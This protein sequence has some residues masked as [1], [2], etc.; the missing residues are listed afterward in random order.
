LAVRCEGEQEEKDGRILDYHRGQ[1]RLRKQHTVLYIYLYLSWL[2][3]RR[4]GGL[5]AGVQ[6]SDGNVL[7]FKNEYS[8]AFD[9]LNTLYCSTTE[10]VVDPCSW[11]V[12]ITHVGNAIRYLTSGFDVTHTDAVH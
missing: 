8:H 1:V 10:V 11:Y 4:I 9:F 6:R 7:S 5:D 12:S 3:N 2:K